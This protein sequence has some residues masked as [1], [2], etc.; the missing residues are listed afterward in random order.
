LIRERLEEIYSI[1]PGADIL[2]AGNLNCFYDQ[3]VRYGWPRTAVNDVLKAQPD[4]RLL[5]GR[6]ADLYNLWYE[7][8]L[9]Q[10]GSGL[11]EGRWTTF[12]QMIVSRGLYDYNGVQYMDNSFEVAAFAGLNVNKE[13]KPYRWS[14][15][16]G[17]HGFSANFP[18]VARFRTVR[19]NRTDQFIDLKIRE[20]GQR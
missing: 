10:R 14:F 4:E 11:I 13:G 1:N 2:I 8:P 15:E 9:T 12:M 7:L 3:K 20:G 18:L 6:S 19:N 16:G 5:R 17:G